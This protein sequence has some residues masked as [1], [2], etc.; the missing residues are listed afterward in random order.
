MTAVKRCDGIPIPDYIFYDYKKLVPN[1]DGLG[2]NV[3]YNEI[4]IFILENKKIYINYLLYSILFTNV[5]KITQLIAYD[6]LIQLQFT[7]KTDLITVQLT[8]V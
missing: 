8:A 3:D 4:I 7:T 1:A 5:N 6:Y 2:G